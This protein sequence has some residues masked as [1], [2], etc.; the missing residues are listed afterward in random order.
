[1][2]GNHPQKECKNSDAGDSSRERM[3]QFRSRGLIHRK[4]A[5][6]QMPGNHPEKECNNSDAGDSSTER[7]QQFRRRG[8]IH[9]KNATIQT[10]GNHPEKECNNSDAGNHPEKECNNSDARD[11]STERM[12]QFRRRGLIQRKNAT[13][14]KPG[15]HPKERISHIIY[16]KP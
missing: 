12:Q 6:I 4:N 1:M 14:Q 16:L 13:I 15:N 8:I 7:M 11:S 5:T 9:R 2:P 10:P 3:Q